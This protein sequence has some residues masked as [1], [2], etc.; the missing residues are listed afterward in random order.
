MASALMKIIEFHVDYMGGCK[1]G[2][3][4]QLALSYELH[5]YITKRCAAAW[6][7]YIVENTPCLAGFP[8]LKKNRSK[9]LETK[10]LRDFFVLVFRCFLCFPSHVQITLIDAV[11]HSLPNLPTLCVTTCQTDRHDVS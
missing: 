5:N 4:L 8:Q 9:I 10:S 1:A 2:A 11:H 6:L 3:D 7:R